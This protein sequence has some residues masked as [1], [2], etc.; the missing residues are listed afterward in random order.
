MEVS[1]L[2]APAALAASKQP[3]P[4]IQPVSLVHKYSAVHP[5]AIVTVMDHFYRLVPE[6][7]QRI[8]PLV[9]DDADESAPNAVRTG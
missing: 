8:L 6:A 4:G 3:Q 9:P 2:P 1:N 5:T 7:L